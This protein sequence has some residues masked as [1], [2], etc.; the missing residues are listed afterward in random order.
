MTRFWMVWRSPGHPPTMRHASR[1][2]AQKEAERLAECCP[3]ESFFVLEAVTVS[4]KVMVV[5]ST[6]DP[7][8]SEIPF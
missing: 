4:R 7:A 3:G 2:L 8:E 6:L 1:L 5:T